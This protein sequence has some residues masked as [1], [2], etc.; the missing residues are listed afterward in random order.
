MSGFTL[1]ELLITVVIVSILATAI[2]PLSELSSQRS[3][4]TEL[5]EALWQIRHGIDAYKQAS[6]EGRITKKIDES[7]YPRT[8][9][10]LVK[11]IPDAKDAKGALIY[12]MRRIPRDPFYPDRSV[13]AT[14]TW[15]LRSYASS[16]DDPKE[17]RDVFDVY[18]TAPG[19]SLDGSEY[20]SW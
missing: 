2:I 15:I 4:E 19:T 18:S 5:R 3:K 17:G 13:A 16:Y 11:G 6:D 20:R 14:K 1:V 12:F 7:G 8:L 10:E 9:D